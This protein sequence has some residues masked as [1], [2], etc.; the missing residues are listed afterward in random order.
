MRV[1]V[2]KKA[3]LLRVAAFVVILA[4]I[5]VYAKVMM[6]EDAAVFSA[7]GV[8]TAGDGAEKAI[9]ITIDTSFGETDYTEEILE[10]LHD[11]GAHAT[12][13]VM[14]AWARQNPDM[15]REILDSG[16]EIISHSMSHQRYAELGEEDAVADARANRDYLA[17]EFGVD[18]DLLRLPY[19]SGTE[20]IHA[21]LEQ[22]GFRI[23]GWSL[24]SRDWNG[25][26]SEKIAES[27][28]GKLKAGDILLF[29]NNVPATP[30]AL[31]EILE[32]LAERAYETVG[33][34]EMAQSAARS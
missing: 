26:S 23:V 13:A 21:A 24:D 3:T 28:L 1:F 25:D 14:G 27:V 10:V 33:L 17:S 5:F 30:D 19:G 18:T 32:K 8:L 11:H 6:H 9:A 22:D 16:H 29:Q 15:V 12:F 4:A 7:N 34:D 2:M 31:D 20:K